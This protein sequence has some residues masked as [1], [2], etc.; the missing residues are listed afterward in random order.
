MEHVRKGFRQRPLPVKL[1]RFAVVSGV[2]TGVDYVILIALHELLPAGALSLSVAVACGYLAGVV[3]HFTL[4][5]QYVFPPSSFDPAVEFGL[6]GLIGLVGLGLTE[7]IVC[8]GVT[9]CGLP[10]LL[11]KTAAVGL[12][13]GWNFFAR[14]QWVYRER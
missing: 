4:A 12:V 11:T 2:S 6:V 5:R 1:A 14:H 3:A 10:V 9:W 8:A 7:A 13:F